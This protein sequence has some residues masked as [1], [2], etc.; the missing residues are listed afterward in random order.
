MDKKRII[1]KLNNSL[2]DLGKHKIFFKDDVIE[3]EVI[4]NNFKG[5]GIPKRIEMVSDAVS[6][7]S[8]N[9]LIDYNLSIIALTE[10]EH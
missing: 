6:D 9:E 5:I 8:M 3:I 1:T 4:S 7:L 2:E 10:D